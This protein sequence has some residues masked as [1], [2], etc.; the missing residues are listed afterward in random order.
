MK[1]CYKRSAAIPVFERATGIMTKRS[2]LM[3]DDLNLEV[4]CLIWRFSFATSL[5]DLQV[6]L[7]TVTLA[8]VAPMFPK[9]IKA[10]YFN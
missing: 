9:L 7:A 5:L 10:A 1:V 2:S 3:V 6:L 8:C 4:F